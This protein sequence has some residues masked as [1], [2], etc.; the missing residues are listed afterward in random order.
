MSNRKKNA[1]R[2]C[3]TSLLAALLL[4]ATLLAGYTPT[5][6]NLT[7]GGKTYAAQAQVDATAK[8]VILGN[9]RNACVPQY[10]EG[11]LTVPGKVTV[12]G[13]ECTVS[14]I[15][16]FAFRLCA[17]LTGVTVSDGVTRVGDCAFVGM[18]APELGSILAQSHPKK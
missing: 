5:T 13:T 15:G 3:I 9:G 10:A 1:D 11:E 16:A 2:N 4:P 12:D 17:G 6:V 18:I 7:I 8:L 14:E